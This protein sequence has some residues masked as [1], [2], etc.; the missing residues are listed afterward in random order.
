MIE[1]IRGVKALPDS[2]WTGGGGTG[3]ELDISLNGSGNGSGSL[4]AY[5][6]VCAGQQTVPPDS[7]LSTFS[8][9]HVNFQYGYSYQGSC[10]G[11]GFSYFTPPTF[12]VQATVPASCTVS[13]GALNFG[14][15]GLLSSTINATS[16]FNGGLLVR[17]RL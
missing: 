9:S 16:S 14:S 15:A 7:F 3:N 12:S 17:Q 4:T 1:P 2:A 11:G 8:S 5:G 6:T 10:S 13:A